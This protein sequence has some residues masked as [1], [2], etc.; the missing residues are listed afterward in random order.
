MIFVT[1][2]VIR[3]LFSLTA[4]PTKVIGE[5]LKPVTQSDILF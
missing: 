4:S 2:E 5:L 1:R 3:H